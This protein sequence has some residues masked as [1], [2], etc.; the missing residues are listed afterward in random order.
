LNIVIL[1]F[2]NN[3][4]TPKGKFIR[5]SRANQEV[6][7]KKIQD[8]INLV[9]QTTP[10][11]EN[12]Q[13]EAFYLLLA[14]K[15]LGI[16]YGLTQDV[17][18]KYLCIKHDTNP[19]DCKWNMLLMSVLL[20][21]YSDNEQHSSGC[22]FLRKVIISKIER[23]DMQNRKI[24]AELTILKM[25]I[26]T[27]PYL[28]EN[29]KRKVLSLYGVKDDKMRRI[30][31]F[32]AKQQSWFTK[33]KNFKLNYE[34]NAKVSQEVYSYNM[35]SATILK[36]ITHIAELSFPFEEIQIEYLGGLGYSFTCTLCANYFGE[37]FDK[38][39]L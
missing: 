39:V 20:H 2:K 28:D 25:D 35:S 34:I 27:C 30:L 15:E 7:F 9:M 29:F 23:E 33:W 5:F 12:I 17:I 36:R 24:S 37:V 4:Q 11:N 16:E 38:V 19:M 32:S 1:Y 13:L 26:L 31:D 3:Y 18:D 6:V 21:Y 22:D 14:L 10:F 8:E